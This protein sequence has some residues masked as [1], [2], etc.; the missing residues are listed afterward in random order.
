MGS[1]YLCADPGLL[2]GVARLFDF[3]NTFDAYNRAT[4]GEEADGVGI[5]WD[6]AMVGQ[7]LSDAVSA[8]DTEVMSSHPQTKPEAAV[9]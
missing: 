8:Y 1:L 6:W 9:R 4:T 2:S 3:G 7:D 5:L